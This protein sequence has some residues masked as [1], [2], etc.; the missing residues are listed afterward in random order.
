MIL[1]KNCLKDTNSRFRFNLLQLDLNLNSFEFAF[2]KIL[3]RS[4]RVVSDWIQK[5][6]FIKII[7]DKKNGMHENFDFMKGSGKNSVNCLDPV[8]HPSDANKF[9]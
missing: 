8:Y 5:F 2:Y 6:L 9:V 7:H 4:S 3:L 1:T